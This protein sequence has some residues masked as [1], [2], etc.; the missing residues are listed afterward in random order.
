MYFDADDLEQISI[1]GGKLKRKKIYNRSL[2]I[3]HLNQSLIT[4]SPFGRLSSYIKAFLDK[5]VEQKN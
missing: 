3:E 2:V 5:Y 4:S 1:H